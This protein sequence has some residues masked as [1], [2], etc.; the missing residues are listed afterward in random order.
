M[1]KRLFTSIVLLLFTFQL[2]SVRSQT[3]TADQKIVKQLIG[4]YLKKNQEQLKLSDDDISNWIISDLYSDKSSSITHAYVQQTISGI[5][6]FNDTN[7]K[8]GGINE[9]P[10]KHS[11]KKHK[12]CSGKDCCKDKK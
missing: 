1:Y 2:F 10:K 8:G 7:G 9:K 5:K 3:P 4:E 11:K 12:K 6:I